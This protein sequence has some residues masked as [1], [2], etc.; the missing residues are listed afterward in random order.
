MQPSEAS[1][2]STP[3]LSVVVITPD[4]FDTVRRTCHCLAAQTIASQ[5]ELVLCVPEA[6]ELEPEVD[7]LA[8]IGKVTLVETGECRVVAEVKALATR[9]ASAPYI[10]F[11][12]E[13]AFPHRHYAE[14]LLEALE[15]GYA[16]VGPLMVNANPKLAASWANFVIEYGPW[17]GWNEARS[18]AHLPGNNGSY[19][20]DA[21]L[22]FGG[23][24]EAMLDAESLLH[25]ELGKRGERLWQATDAKVFHVNITAFEPFWKVHF[26]YS[27]MF[28]S[29]RA[30]RW[31]IWKRLI[32]TGGAGLIP[33]IRLKRHWADIWR[34]TPSTARGAA[35]W[36]L[37]ALGLA[38]AAAGES[39]GYLIGVGKSREHIYWLEFHRPRYLAKGDS[40]PISAVP[41][42]PV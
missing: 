15:Q 34:V 11:I 41:E 28:A 40:I 24:L 22:S 37:L 26:H 10:A 12:E 19:R 42:T 1:T 20:R 30:A 7:I 31:P 5:L 13:H 23:Q 36:G 2:Q 33:L 25:W 16:A 9:R 27:R 29:A 18:P 32:Y 39:A 8:R 3:A 6:R 38:S 35:F 21:L 17:A 4:R 14:R